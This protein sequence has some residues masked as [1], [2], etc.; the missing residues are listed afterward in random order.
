MNSTKESMSLFGNTH[1]DNETLS[2]L[3]GEGGPLQNGVLPQADTALAEGEKELWSTLCKVP[4]TKQKDKPKRG[5]GDPADP[6]APKTIKETL[7]E[8]W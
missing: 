3:T 1:P 6:V 2:S 4:I 5:A 7:I 8:N